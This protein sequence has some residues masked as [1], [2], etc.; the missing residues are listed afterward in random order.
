[1]LE[2]NKKTM[3]LMARQKIKMM[4]IEAARSRKRSTNSRENIEREQ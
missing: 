4:W 3:L 1:M 2:I